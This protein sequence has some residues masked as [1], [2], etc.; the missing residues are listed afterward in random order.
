MEFTLTP[1]ALL[2]AGLIFTLRVTDMTLDTLRVLFV[3]RGRKPIAWILGFFQAAVFV[4]AITF[5][6]RDLTNVL[7]IIGYAAG[8]ATG[9]VV[10]MTI[11]ERLAI[12]H[13][14]MRIISSRRGS[15]IAEKIREEGYAV[16]EVPARGKDGTVTMLNCSVLRKNAERVRVMVNEIDPEAF[17]TSEDIRPIRRGF[18]RA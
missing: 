14:H 16:T 4:V 18:W 13:I 15:R 7:N 2:S 11:E 8:F 10:G 3:M 12:G 1:E 5:V 9:V 17:I 6:L